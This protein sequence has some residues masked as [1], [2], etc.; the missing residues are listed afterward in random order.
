MLLMDTFIVMTDT[1]HSTVISIGI[2]DQF[3]NFESVHSHY[4]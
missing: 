2:L 3:S 4:F 1:L